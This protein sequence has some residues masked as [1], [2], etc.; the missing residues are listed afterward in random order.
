MTFDTTVPSVLVTACC[1]PITS[2]FIRDCSAPSLRAGE[3]RDRHALHV[4]EQ[5]RRAGRRSGLRRCAPRPALHERRASRWRTRAP[6]APSASH[7]TSA[8]FVVGDGVCRAAPCSSSGGTAVATA[9]SDDCEENPTSAPRYG[10]DVG[11]DPPH[12][13]P[14][15]VAARGSRLS[16]LKPMIV[17][18]SIMRAVQPYRFRRP[19]PGL[20]G[21]SRLAVA[22]AAWPPIPRSAREVVDTVRRFVARDVIPVASEF[23]HADAYPEAI[24]E[25]MKRARPV[26]RH[27][28]GGVRRPRAST[29]SPTSGSSRSSPTAGCRSSGIV[30]TH[31]I[32]A[33]P[34]RARTAPRSRSSAG[35]RA[36]RPARC[37]A[38]CRCRSPTRAAT[39][40]TCRAGPCATAT[41]TS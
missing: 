40:A 11:E 3:E 12:D 32:A 23:E 4:V 27:D 34:D 16:R 8:R 38:A 24:V 26:R 36:W 1:A 19:T 15:D 7:A 29:S 41:S 33:Q 13:L 18:W 22:L 37:A 30:N 35:C 31:T 28:P 39:R 6:T 9:P 10:A 17:R 2:L 5:L 21:S 14:V 20:R 25:Q